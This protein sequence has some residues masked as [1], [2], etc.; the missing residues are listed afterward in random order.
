MRRY[1]QTLAGIVGFG[2]LLAATPV[3]AVITQ[4]TPLQSLLQDT[5]YILTAKVESVDAEKP[6]V[7]LVA[8]EQL[9][10]KAPFE[11]MA[12]LFKG[13]SEAKKRQHVP[14]LL[15]RVTC[16]RRRPRLTAQRVG[17]GAMFRCEERRGSVEEGARRWGNV[18]FTRACSR[19][20]V[21]PHHGR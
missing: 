19:P 3:Q 6:A 13:D 15:K 2:L 20:T 17:A 16:P 11:T 8:G 1:K 18:E 10:G 7:V 12:V 21:R 14:Q 4:L 9:Q 5:T